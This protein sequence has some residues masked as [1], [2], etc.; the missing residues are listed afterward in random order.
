MLAQ[1]EKRELIKLLVGI[2]SEIKEDRDILKNSLQNLNGVLQRYYTITDMQRV[3]AHALYHNASILQ[4]KKTDKVPTNTRCNVKDIALDSRYLIES[5]INE[6]SALGIPKHVKSIEDNSVNVNTT[7]SQNQE[8]S[9]NQ[10]QDVIVNILLE[11]VKDELTGKQRKELL[12]V[13]KETTDPEEIRQNI[14]HKIKEFGEDVA[15]NIVAN[16]MM[17]PKVWQSLS[18]LL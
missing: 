3:C 13:T 2:K 12:G 8:Q 9:Q 16:I 4:N 18:S 1:E 11:A 7:V 15:A 10:H 5:I 14:F 17:N 6:V